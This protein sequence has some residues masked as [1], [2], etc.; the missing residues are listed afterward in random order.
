MTIQLK[1]F[2]LSAALAAM[3]LPAAAQDATTQ[4]APEP[5]QKHETKFRERQENE[6]KRIKQGVKSGELT[7]GEAARLERQ[8]RAMNREAR[9]MREDNGG[10]LTKADR[11][12]LNRQQNRESRKIYRAKHNDRERK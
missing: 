5:P 1:S 12:K 4:P 3:I 8:H 7:R 10:K 2:F 6:Q 9:D 11:E